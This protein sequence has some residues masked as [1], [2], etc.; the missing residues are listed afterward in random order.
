[1]QI[2]S[3]EELGRVYDWRLLKWVWS[4]VRPYR[5]LFWFSMLLMPL[6][7]VLALTHGTRMA[8]PDPSRVR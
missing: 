7:S 5:R 1:M 2:A 3:E 8:R 4:Y 6:N